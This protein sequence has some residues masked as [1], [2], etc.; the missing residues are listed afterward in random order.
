MVNH[1]PAPGIGSRPHIALFIVMLTA[2]FTNSR[3]TLAESVAGRTRAPWEG[4]KKFLRVPMSTVMVLNPES[5]MRE[6]NCRIEQADLLAAVEQTGNG[7][8]ITGIDGEIRYVN[9]AFTAMTGYTREEV[10]GQNMRIL[11]S[12]RNPAE[13]YAELWSTIRAGHLWHGELINRR[14]DGSFYTEEMR[15]APVRGPGG[16]IESYIAVKQDVTE[17]RAAEITLRESEERFRIMADGCPAMMW[18]TNAEGELQFINRAYRE[19]CGTTYEE[20]QKAKWQLLI[21]PD[22]APEYV[23]AF[24]RAVREHAP[25]RAEV[26]RPP[27]RRRVA[28]ARL[29]RGAALFAGWRV[30]GARRPQSGHHR[31]QASRAGLAEQRGEISP[32]GGKHS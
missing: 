28:V 25:F 29:Q 4:F 17:R 23:E 22:D 15:I 20:V 3:A 1:L 7:I 14:K 21:H 5:K 12:G 10:G 27:R 24:Q 16:E 11:K 26:A 32:V 2:N 8:V 18:V 19:F 6:N 31:A 30:S 9:P 13:F